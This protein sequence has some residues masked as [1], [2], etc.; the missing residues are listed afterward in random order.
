MPDRHKNPPKA[1]RMPDGLLAWY[2]DRAADTGQP[3]NALIVAALED[4]RQRQDGATAPEPARAAGA[5]TRPARA[6]P[7]RTVAAPATELPRKPPSAERGDCPHPKA[8]IT[9]GLCN[10]C[11]T[12]VGS[13]K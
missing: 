2:E 3:V 9:K 1:V 5:T 8:R 4:N 7:A 6:K 11:G 13:A 12:N 10:A